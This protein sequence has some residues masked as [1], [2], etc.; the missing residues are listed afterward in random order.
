MMIKTIEKRAMG[1]IVVKKSRFIA[2]IAPAADKQEAESFIA[3]MKK[4]YWDA[5]HNCSAYILLP[6][7]EGGSLYVHSS[8]D[9]EPAGTAGKPMLSVLQGADVAGIVVVVTRYFGGVLLGTGGLIRAYQDAVTEGLKSAELLEQKRV[10]QITM[11]LDYTL[12][13]KL[14][15]FLMQQE[16]I[17]C[18]DPEYAENVKVSILVPSALTEGYVEKLIQT[19]NGKAVIEQGDELMINQ[20]VSV[21]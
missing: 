12:W 19:T 8:D 2:N 11:T 1:E 13:G 15:S 5:R 4:E 14:Q 18:N 16:D 21:M 10:R 17:I 6:E 3:Q 20:P 7:T 9:G